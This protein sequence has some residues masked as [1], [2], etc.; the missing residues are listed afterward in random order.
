MMLCTRARP[1][2]RWQ[3][4]EE[5]CEEMTSGLSGRC[6][7]AVLK[8]GVRTIFMSKRS[9]TN[10]REKNDIRKTQLLRSETTRRILHFPATTLF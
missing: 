7:F 6:M 5:K 4:W 3:K 8:V 1:L 2:P 10:T 9:T